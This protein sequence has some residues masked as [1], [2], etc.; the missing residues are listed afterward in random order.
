MQDDSVHRGSPHPCIGDSE[1]NKKASSVW[2]WVSPLSECSFLPGF[3]FWFLLDSLFSQRGTVARTYKPHKPFSPLNCFESWGLSQQQ[4][5][6]R[7]TRSQSRRVR[8][9]GYTG[10]LASQK[11]ANKQ[12][13]RTSVYWTLCLLAT[14]HSSCPPVQKTTVFDLSSA[15]CQPS[16][17]LWHGHA[18]TFLTS[19]CFLKPGHFV[20]SYVGTPWVVCSVLVHR[21]SHPMY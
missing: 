9:L 11:Q 16:P 4:N 17:Y 13:L 2:P 8:G 3:C 6:T 15:L 14:D 21:F 5:E 12:Q 7:T 19:S 20:V 18:T 10:D 1:L